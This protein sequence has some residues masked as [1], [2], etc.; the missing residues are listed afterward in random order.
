MRSLPQVW[1][2][3]V[4]R[5]EGPFAFRFYLQPLM[6]IL[7][8]VRDGLRDAAAGR[9]P[10]LWSLFTNPADRWER[11]REGWRSVG[12]ILALAIVLDLLY[13]V[14]VFHGVRPVKGF[15]EGVLALF[16]GVRPVEGLVVAF[17]LA[18][19]PYALLRGPVN[20]LYRRVSRRRAAH[21][22]AAAP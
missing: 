12:K 22:R 2:E 1:R 9:P 21:R 17:T 4:A 14:V 7:F 18:V 11:V 3:I 13:Q 20:R 6:A 15:L 16:L 10:Y 8:A 5:T 19:V